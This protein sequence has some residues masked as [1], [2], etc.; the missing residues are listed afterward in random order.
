M[1]H[2]LPQNKPLFMTSVSS[3]QTYIERILTTE[4]ANLIG[5]WPM[6]EPSGSTADNAEGTAARD[7]TYTDA[8]LA[9][10]GIGD[11]ETS[12]Y[13]DGSASYNNVQT[14]SLASAFN[15]D[16]GTLVVWGKVYDASVWEDSAYRDLFG[17]YVDAANSIR[18]GKTNT[19]NQ[20]RGR[21]ESGNAVKSITGTLST[22]DFFQMA[23]T[24]DS[25]ADE[26]KLFVD[27]SQEGATASSLGTWAGTP[28]H[29]V[30][31]AEYIGGANW[32]GYE[33]HGGVWT[34][35]LTPAQILALASV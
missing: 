31:G 18:L 28:S 15:G 11:G 12:V 23:I 16:A 2:I 20:I 33:A 1:K 21:Y 24:W 8:T 29:F 10:T 7:G 22:T 4:A 30:L 27:G 9:Q 5:Y 17:I 25:V 32:N 6:N 35:A 19:N 34:K 13:F 3:S 14:A 26:V